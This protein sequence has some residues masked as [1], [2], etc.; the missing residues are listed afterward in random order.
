MGEVKY[1]IEQHGDSFVLL[2]VVETNLGEV[3]K[4]FVR[5]GQTV[6]ELA[7]TIRRLQNES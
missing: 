2:K 6:G 5:R 1:E 7:A 3:A 4:T